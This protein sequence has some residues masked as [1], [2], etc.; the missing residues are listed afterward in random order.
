MNIR[1]R[2]TFDWGIY[3][4]PA[5]NLINRVHDEKHIVFYFDGIKESSRF[6]FF[7]F[8]FGQHAPEVF[9]RTFRDKRGKMVTRT[10]KNV[11]GLFDKS[12]GYLT[13]LNQPIKKQLG[14]RNDIDGGPTFWPKYIS[15]DDKMV[16]WWNAEEFLSLYEQ[17]ENP[18]PELQK[19]A[20]KLTPDDN[21]VLM[22]VTLK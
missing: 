12:T 8:Y 16:A 14:F 2:F 13:L 22:V 1:A 11:Y 6:L 20:G 7:D 4:E 5:V 15:S 17:L 10:Y 9:E 21:P 18:S 3:K 19:L